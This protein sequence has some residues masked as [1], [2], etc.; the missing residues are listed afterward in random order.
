MIKK[1]AVLQTLCTACGRHLVAIWCTSYMWVRGQVFVD[2]SGY[3]V[4]CMKCDVED[5]VETEEEGAAA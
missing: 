3:M 2:D 4:G 5:N 1:E